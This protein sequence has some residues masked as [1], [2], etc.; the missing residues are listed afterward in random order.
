[1]EFWV[2]HALV[3]HHYNLYLSE[4]ALASLYWLIAPTTHVYHNL[5]A[6]IVGTLETAG[7]PSTRVSQVA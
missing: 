4:V 1:M 6:S 7:Y 2:S 5:R 3:I